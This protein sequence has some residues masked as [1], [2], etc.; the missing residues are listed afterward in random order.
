MT[1]FENERVK[2]DQTVSLNESSAANADLLQSGV[3]VGS[4]YKVV[5]L[6]G[7][8]GLC[9]VYK[10]QHLITNQ[11][12]AMKVLHKHLSS[13]RNQIMRFK[14]EGQTSSSLTHPNIVRMYDFGITEDGIPFMTMDLISG[15]AL[16]QVIHDE[17][18]VEVK[19]ALDIFIQTCK[20]LAYAHGR[21]IIHRDIKPNNIM[22]SED[23]HGGQLAQ[24]VDFGLAKLVVND[25]PDAQRLTAT[26]E[27]MGSPYYM[28]PE[29]CLGQ[30]LSPQSDIYSFGCVMYETLSGQAPFAGA[31][32]FDTIRQHIEASPQ[33]LRSINPNCKGPLTESLEHIIFRCLAKDPAQRYDSV[34]DLLAELEN[35]KTSQRSGVFKTIERS[36]YMQKATKKKNSSN[37]LILVALFLVALLVAGYY[38]WANQE[39]TIIVA[40]PVHSSTRTAPL[41]EAVEERWTSVMDRVAA[42]LLRGE[43]VSAANDLA[44]ARTT[45]MTM[46]DNDKEHIV[47]HQ[48][49]IVAHILKDKSSEGTTAAWLKKSHSDEDSKK[50]AELA[51]Q[52]QMWS[53]IP[54]QPDDSQKPA[55]RA[56][57]SEAINIGERARQ[58]QDG[59]K[60][61]ISLL[62]VS[63][64]KG[65][66]SLGQTDASI[67]RAEFLLGRILE[68]QR[69]YK[70]ALEQFESA[71]AALSHCPE[72]KKM[73]PILAAHIAF[74]RYAHGGTVDESLRDLREIASK[75]E[76]AEAAEL[77]YLDSVLS[78]LLLGKTD[79]NSATEHAVKASKN[80]RAGQEHFMAADVMETLTVPL[81]IRSKQFAKAEELINSALSEL[82]QSG[83]EN[84]ELISTYYRLLSEVH[85]SN[86]RIPD[87][88]NDAVQAFTCAV[89]TSPATHNKYKDVM[90]YMIKFSTRAADFKALR[91]LS[92]QELAVAEISHEKKNGK[93]EAMLDRLGFAYANTNDTPK[94]HEILRN[95]IKQIRETPDGSMPINSE[96]LS[97]L[98]DK[99]GTEQQKSEVPTLFE[100]TLPKVTERVNVDDYVDCLRYLGRIYVVQGHANDAIRSYNRAVQYALSKKDIN[101][102]RNTLEDMS[103]LYGRLGRPADARAVIERANSL[104]RKP[105]K[106]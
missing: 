16:S 103:V 13:N 102:A 27:I 10:A 55:I 32:I 20:G 88:M 28:S 47:L 21:D 95:R 33:R 12:I 1:Q 85:A 54:K 2:I 80:L 57:I 64:S 96:Y 6:I 36:L 78:R 23:G 18:A 60:R 56:M 61:A 25:D 75:G 77:G 100:M 62:K 69:H 42:E 66:S 53:V 37:A 70:L 82:R 89:A 46:A 15:K 11:L 30:V 48:Q 93:Y 87:A 39:K 8:G 59:R 106:I 5:E 72:L 84:R 105:A 35:L 7:S 40:A 58:K 104:A 71:N 98:L 86:N 90:Q 43:Y 51:M 73:Q 44:I 31:S 99:V 41:P 94:A 101:S 29:Q 34:P 9:N 76:L 26:G 97:D 38:A 92:E 17:G 81:L 4:K 52:E 3:I 67:I 65:T 19:R 79:D 50:Y 49:Q 22:I 14:Q 45:A 91:A 83:I 24:L 68:E 74:L 63:I